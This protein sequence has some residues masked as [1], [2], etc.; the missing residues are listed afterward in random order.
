MTAVQTIRDKR[1]IADYLRGDSALHIYELGDLDE[2]FWPSTLWYA[3]LADGAIEG[4]VMVYTGFDVPTLIALDRRE[5][6][7]RLCG[8]VRSVAQSLEGPFYAHISVGAAPALEPWWRPWSLGMVKMLQMNRG[9]VPVGPDREIACLDDRDLSDIKELLEIA[10]PSHWFDPRLLATG[11]YL[12][13]R[14]GRALVSMAGVH[15][16]SASYRV[17]ALGNIA[18]HPDYCGQGL[19]RRTTAE[20]CRRL[21]STCDEIGLN[22]AHDN[23][24]ALRCYRGLGFEICDRYLEARFERGRQGD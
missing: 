17:A 24:A 3:T 23:Q 8:L 18:T 20:L 1:A 21:S 19:A 6:G 5:D 12:G 22:V 14:R 7:A 15:V 13:L 16:I 11:Y 9:L 2:R 10:H 4:L